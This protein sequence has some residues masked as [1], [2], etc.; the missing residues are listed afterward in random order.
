M[1]EALEVLI[2]RGEVCQCSVVKGKRTYPGICWRD[3][4]QHVSTSVTTGTWSGN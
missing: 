3:P 2:G 1:T 4:H